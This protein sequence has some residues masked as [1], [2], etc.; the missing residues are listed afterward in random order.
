MMYV[1][2]LCIVLCMILLLQMNDVFDDHL[3]SSED[4]RKVVIRKIPGRTLGL[5]IRGGKEFHLGI[6]VIG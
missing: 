3:L 4:K 1:Y 5:K 6:F 2:T